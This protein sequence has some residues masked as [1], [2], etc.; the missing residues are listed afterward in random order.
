VEIAVIGS[1]SKRYAVTRGLRAAVARLGSSSAA[2]D[3]SLILIVV[4]IVEESSWI[5]DLSVVG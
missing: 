5:E 1:W 4:G 3:R 2:I